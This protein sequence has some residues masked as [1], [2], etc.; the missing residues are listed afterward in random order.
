MT[1]HRSKLAFACLAAAALYATY[2]LSKSRTYQVFGDML[3]RVETEDKIVALTF[4]DGPTKDATPEILRILKDNDVRASF[5]LCGREIEANPAEAAAIAAAGHEIGN[6]TYSHERMVFRSW[7]YVSRE[8]EQTD[9]LIRKTGFQGPVYFRAPYGKRLLLLPFYLQQTG[10]LHVFCDV[11]PESFS[12][13]A[14]NTEKIVGH[15][16]AN[17][18]PGSIILLHVMYPKATRDA[19]PG[20]IQGL[21]QRGYSFATVSELRK[22]TKN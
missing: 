20:I 4:D 17:T 13:V 11:E 16:L 14:G 1:R 9:A 19:V 21:K 12:E 18:R 6:H 15:V 8:I 22:L 5:F 7:S 3:T 2:R 10:R